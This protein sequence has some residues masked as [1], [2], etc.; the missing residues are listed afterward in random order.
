MHTARDH[1]N[2]DNTTKQSGYILEFTLFLVSGFKKKPRCPGF[3]SE[4]LL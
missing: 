1:G 4:I 3:G 2:P